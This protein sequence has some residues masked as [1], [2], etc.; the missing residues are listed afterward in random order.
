MVS[1]P[2]SRGMTTHIVFQGHRA[3]G[4]F[5]TA[6]ISLGKQLDRRAQRE[7]ANDADVPRNRGSFV[8]RGLSLYKILQQPLRT[9]RA[10]CID[11]TAGGTANGPGSR[12]CLDRPKGLDRAA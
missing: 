7:N 11:G 10:P 5:S 12:F 6:G 4:A 8:R 1:R 9:P 3:G 2:S